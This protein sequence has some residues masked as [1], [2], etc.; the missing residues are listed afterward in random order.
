MEAHARVFSVG[1]TEWI[2]LGKWYSLEIT[3]Y[4][5]L[6]PDCI[7]KCATKVRTSQQTSPQSRLEND[8][9]GLV[10]FGAGVY[11]TPFSTVR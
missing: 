6:K 3:R 1:S 2:Y 8:F 11:D 5:A 7:I 9:Y 10:G 4:I